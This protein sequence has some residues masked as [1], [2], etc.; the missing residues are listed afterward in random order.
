MSTPEHTAIREYLHQLLDLAKEKVEIEKRTRLIEKA[1]RSLIDLIDGEDEQTKLLEMLDEI[2][3]PAGLTNAIE[4][5]LAKAGSA[6][7]T[8][9]ETRDRVAPLLFGHSNPLASVH[10][11][12]KRLAR[13][14]KARLTE[15]NGEPAYEWVV[16]HQRDKSHWAS[17]ALGSNPRA[18]A[19]IEEHLDKKD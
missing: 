3:R 7:L 5:Q 13:N 2:V 19:L 18:K 8:P 17:R 16:P 14:G 15:K 4:G 1:V 10:T 9:K 6:K 11:V 12:L